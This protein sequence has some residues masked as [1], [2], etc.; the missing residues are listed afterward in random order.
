MDKAP[1]LQSAL[2]TRK[3]ERVYQG[4]IKF[5]KVSAVRTRAE[6]SCQAW[7]IEGVYDTLVEVEDSSWAEE[8]RGDTAELWREHWG[9][10]T[11]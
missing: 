7:Y 4:G 11:T 3:T 2:A 6:R 5:N 10:T 8:I 9:Y 1:R